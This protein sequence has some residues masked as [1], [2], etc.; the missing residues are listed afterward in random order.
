MMIFNGGVVDGAR[1]LRSETVADMLSLQFPKGEKDP[2]AFGLGFM[3]GEWQGRTKAVHGGMIYGFASLLETLP[4]E[5]LAVVVLNTVD[6]AFGLNTKV[7]AEAVRLM[8]NARDGAGIEPPP[9]LEDVPVGKQMKY[10]GKYLSDDRQA[11]VTSDRGALEIQ[12]DGWTALIRE[13]SDGE[14]ITDGRVSHGVKIVFRWD[15][16]GRIIGLKAGDRDYR[17]VDDSVPDHSVP[18][19]WAHLVGDY[20]LPYNVMRIYVLDGRLWCRVEFVL[21]YPMTEVEDDRFAFPDYGAYSN[22]EIVFK[23]GTDGNI[24]GAEMAS[25]FFPVMS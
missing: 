16:D 9:Q 25:V 23:R 5:K 6:A 13:Q 20:G 10:V 18:P 15:D 22:E 4:E 11:F 8:L 19:R 12:Y 24:E 17:K 7:A 3:I 14:F 2:M 21:E 1:I